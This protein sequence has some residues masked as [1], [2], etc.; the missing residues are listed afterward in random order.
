MTFLQVSRTVRGVKPEEA[1][2]A[3][4][5]Y[6]AAGRFVLASHARQRMGERNVTFRD[7]RQALTNAHM[8]SAEG[9]RWR[10][11]GLDWD[12]DELVLI[13]VIEDGLIVVTVF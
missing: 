13:C 2:E 4:R 12:G 9:A 7:V 3:V 1:L 5:G 8:C 10:V 11:E 6:A